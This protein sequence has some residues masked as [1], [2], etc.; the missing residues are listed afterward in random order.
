MSKPRYVLYLA[1]AAPEH[2]RAA[3]AMVSDGRPGT[4]WIATGATL[5]EAIAKLDAQWEKDSAYLRE[6]AR[7]K[8]VRKTP[9]T[10]DDDCG[11]VL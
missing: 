6:K 9:P 10:D 2:M 8:P 1:E 5:E 3:A 7:K 11:I 4:H